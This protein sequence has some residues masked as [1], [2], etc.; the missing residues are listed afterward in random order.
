METQRMEAARNRRRREAER[1]YANFRTAKGQLGWANQKLCARQMS[2][3]LMSLFRRDTYQELEDVGILRSPAQHAMESRF[4]PSLYNQ[5][6]AELQ[7]DNEFTEGVDSYI[8][9]TLRAFAREHKQSI[10]K[11]GK[12]REEKKRNE[13]R[14]QKQKEEEKRKRREVRAALRE[15][16]RVLDL[17][18]RVISQMIE[19]S[20]IEDKFDPER[21]RVFDIRDPEGNEEGIYLIGGMMAELM[22]TF[23]CLLDYILANPQNQNF[24]FSFDS[25]T[26]YLKS[27]LIGHNFPDGAITLHV[28][29]IEGE[30]EI[31]DDQFLRHCLTKT[32][33][34]DYGLHFFFDINREMVIAKEFIECLYRAIVKITRKQPQEPVEVP[35]APEPKEEGA[36][37]TEEE[38]ANFDKSV[39][40]AKTKNEQIHKENEELAQMQ[41]KIKIEFRSHNFED[42]NE[43]A[44]IKLKNY[45]EP[46]KEQPAQ[47]A[48]A[49][50]KQSEKLA[51]V[52]KDESNLDESRIESVKSNEKEDG[53][54]DDVPPKIILANPHLS[55]DTNAI[56]VHTE[57]QMGLRKLL[58]ETAK[59]HFKEL[60]K[61]DVNS[62]FTHP[63]NKSEVLEERF[64][65]HAKSNIQFDKSKPVPVFE[66]QNNTPP[67]P[68]EEEQQPTPPPE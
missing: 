1:R 68:D 52:S 9:M 15:K 39:E 20:K 60:E 24:H 41:S 37:I 57:A 38:K 67:N 54:F 43:C 34:N 35:E 17:K 14:I 31:S 65:A 66:F 13:F 28:N 30:D 59:K 16:A 42:N 50:K 51:D 36:E 33:I 12:R 5:T 29:D 53:T 25:I 62:V 55:D 47:A 26:E 48:E 19:P 22:I 10:Q 56:I 7:R 8:M 4:L 63:K 44:L 40:E 3:K 11:E 64:I 21:M 58:I 6:R 32:N 23:T 45:R 2:K 18:K 49:Q 27:L 61:L 46:P